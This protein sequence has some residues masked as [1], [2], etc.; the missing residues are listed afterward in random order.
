[1]GIQVEEV[2]EVG[3]DLITNIMSPSGPS[4]M[5]LPPIKTIDKNKKSIWQT[6]ASIPPTA[7]RVEQKYFVPSTEYECLYTHPPH[8]PG[9]LV[10]VT[11]NKRERQGNQG[12]TSKAKEAK[13]MDLFGR[14]MYYIG[15]L[16]LG[17]ANQQAVLSRYSFF[18][19][20]DD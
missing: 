4:R 17:V 10:V 13:K 2:S 12:S 1:M 3:T 8:L 15:G 6:P 20:E 11:A 16:Q 18:G 14:K 9:S 7:K 19:W 5:A